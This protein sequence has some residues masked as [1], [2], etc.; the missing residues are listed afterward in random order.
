[1]IIANKVDK[2]F[3]IKTVVKQIIL[4]LIEI[5]EDNINK[6]IDLILNIMVLL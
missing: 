2:R 6:E 5:N 4:E 3:T 1:M